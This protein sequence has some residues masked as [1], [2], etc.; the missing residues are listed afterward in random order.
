MGKFLFFSLKN[1]QQKAN[2]KY[3][4]LHFSGF[5]QYMGKFVVDLVKRKLNFFLFLLTYSF[6]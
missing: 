1:N 2:S 6:I 3:I 4:V 5:L